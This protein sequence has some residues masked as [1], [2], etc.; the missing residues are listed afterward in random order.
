MTATE[1]VRRLGAQELTS[2]ELVEALLERI[3]RFDRDAHLVR[4]G[5]GTLETPADGVSRA[6]SPEARDPLGAMYVVR[7]L[8]WDREDERRL[9]VSDLGM[10]LSVDVRA[11]RVDRVQAEGRTQDARRLAVRMEYVTEHDKTP[12]ATVWLSTDA[13]RIPL[14][15]E[16]ETDAGVFRMALVQ[17]VPG[18]RPPAAPV[19]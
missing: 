7:T 2:V 16:V 14:V 3:A 1:M 13:R 5:T 11:G 17:Y 15:A 18:G 10:E 9:L 12:R 8:P 6:L 19:R 4:V